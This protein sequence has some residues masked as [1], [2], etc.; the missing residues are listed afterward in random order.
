M[1]LYEYDTYRGCR[2]SDDP[3]DWCRNCDGWGRLPVILPTEG[4]GTLQV[5]KDCEYCEGTGKVSVQV[6]RQLEVANRAG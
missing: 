6:R 5:F 2:P 3:A 1:S 4:I